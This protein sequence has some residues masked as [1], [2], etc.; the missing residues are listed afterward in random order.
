MQLL[1]GNL[2]L[3]CKSIGDKHRP[4]NLT[5][6]GYGR[7]SFSLLGVFRPINPNAY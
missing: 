3:C 7:R 2:L 4:L 6:A 1:I 5:S